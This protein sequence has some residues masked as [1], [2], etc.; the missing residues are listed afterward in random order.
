[1]VQIKDLPGRN[2]LHCECPYTRIHM[3]RH[4]KHCR[5]CSICIGKEN[6]D[7]WFLKNQIDSFED[8]IKNEGAT[9]NRVNQLKEYEKKYSKKIDVINTITL[10]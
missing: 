8:W 3:T 10:H 4:N 6:Y 5:R 9:E 2:S 7:I 1:M